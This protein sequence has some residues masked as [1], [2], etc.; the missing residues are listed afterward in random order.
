MQKA[1]RV[2]GLAGEWMSAAVFP[3][4]PL[5]NQLAALHPGGNKSSQSVE[6]GFLRFC[7]YERKNDSKAGLSCHCMRVVLIS[8]S[9]CSKV[10]LV[11]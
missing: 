11:K 2:V 8:V 5:L 9:D 3:D 1:W 6:T 10:K 4:L 7:F